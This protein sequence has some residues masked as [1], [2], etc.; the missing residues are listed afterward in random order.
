MSLWSSKDQCLPTQIRW[1]HVYSLYSLHKNLVRCQW[2]INNASSMMQ[3][4]SSTTEITVRCWQMKP[5]ISRKS[6]TTWGIASGLHK[7]IQGGLTGLP[8]TME[9]VCHELHWVVSHVTHVTLL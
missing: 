2:S 6:N 5:N 1:L 7:V 3:S 4:S 9:A 8:E